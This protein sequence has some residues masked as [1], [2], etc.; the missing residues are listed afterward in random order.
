MANMTEEDWAM[1]PEGA[2]QWTF[3]EW[4]IWYDDVEKLA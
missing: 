3:P 4:A 2:D 1:Y